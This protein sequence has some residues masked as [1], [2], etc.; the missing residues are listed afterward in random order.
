MSS[1][2]YILGTLRR[3]GSGGP[4]SMPHP[5]DLLQMTDI[6]EY[7]ALSSGGVRAYARFAKWT[8]P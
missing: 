2:I 7:Y 5:G 4:V 3:G 6:F 8:R 1:R